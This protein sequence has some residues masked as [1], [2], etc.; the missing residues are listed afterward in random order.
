MTLALPRGPKACTLG[1]HDRLMSEYH[2]LLLFRFA[3]VR[4]LYVIFLL[5][6]IPEVTMGN[7]SLLDEG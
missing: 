2:C 5:L 1:R 4:S 6:L 7:V 3:C